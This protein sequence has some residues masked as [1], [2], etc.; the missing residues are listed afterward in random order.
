VLVI[1]ETEY[2]MINQD[3]ETVGIGVYGNLVQF[4]DED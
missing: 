1:V 3:D 2:K 4:G